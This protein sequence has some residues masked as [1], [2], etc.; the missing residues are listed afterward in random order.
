MLLVDCLLGLMFWTPEGHMTNPKWFGLWQYGGCAQRSAVCRLLGV[1]WLAGVLT[2]TKR[3]FV[4][5]QHLR[6]LFK[7]TMHKVSQSAA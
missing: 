2:A 5:G 1:L 7:T 3:L 4:N 6:G